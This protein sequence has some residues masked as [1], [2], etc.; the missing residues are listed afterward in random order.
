MFLFKK[1]YIYLLLISFLFSACATK[2]PINNS[3]IAVVSKTEID[4]VKKTEVS[5]ISG[6]DKIN[7]E[8]K[9]IISLTN[10]EKIKLKLFGNEVEKIK[11]YKTF[12]ITNKVEY[13]TLYLPIELP[14]YSKIYFVK[15]KEGKVEEIEFLGVQIDR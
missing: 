7:N 8:T 10:F 13:E 1:N 6:L 14:N 2:E 4:M 3:R 9:E 12:I 15:N 11:A 5:N